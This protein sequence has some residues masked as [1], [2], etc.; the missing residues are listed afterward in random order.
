MRYTDCTVTSG[1]L[2][3]AVPEV[4]HTFMLHYGG[5]DEGY[6]IQRINV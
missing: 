2:F 1:Q 6:D 4:C 5:P 3:F